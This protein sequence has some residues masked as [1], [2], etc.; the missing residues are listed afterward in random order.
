MKDFHG[1]DHF[2]DLFFSFLALGFTNK[3]N[4]NLMINIIIKIKMFSIS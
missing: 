2:Q 3:R 1:I 4:I